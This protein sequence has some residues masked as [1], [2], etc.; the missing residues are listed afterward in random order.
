[1]KRIVLTACASIIFS[2]SF[3]QNINS[4]EILKKEL[5]D[6]IEFISE[7]EVRF[8][9]IHK[10]DVYKITRPNPDFLNFIFLRLFNDSEYL[11]IDETVQNKRIFHENTLKEAAI[12][13]AQLA[14][15]C[16]SENKTNSCILKQMQEKLGINICY[17]IYDEGQYCEICDNNTICKKL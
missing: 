15:Y 5:G 17:G 14:H 16:L 1:M 10:C 7:T 9:P 13:R 6:T 3:A 8:C 2:S 11:T 4:K 12:L